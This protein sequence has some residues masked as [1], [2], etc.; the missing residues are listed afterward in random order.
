MSPS[1]SYER[2][3]NIGDELGYIDGFTHADLEPNKISLDVIID[4]SLMLPFD[5]GQFKLILVSS[6]FKKLL[7]ENIAYLFRE[8]RRILHDDGSIILHFDGTCK[9]GKISSDDFIY[10][11]HFSGLQTSQSISSYFSNLPGFNT[12]NQDH[13]YTFHKPLI[14][15]N[16]DPLVSILIPAFRPDF[17]KQ[18]LSS[19]L[20]QTYQNIEILIGDDSL[21][22]DIEAIVNSFDFKHVPVTYIKNPIRLKERE[23]MFQL[24]RLSKGD[25]IKFLNHDDI[26]Y[27][28]CIE[29]MAPILTNFSE[30][31]LVTSKRRIIDKNGAN[32]FEFNLPM[33]IETDVVFYGDKIVNLMSE[34]DNFVGEPTTAI[35]RKN[36]LR[37]IKPHFISLNNTPGVPGA[38]GDVIMWI[39]LLG[40]GS[41]A[42]LNSILSATRSHEGQSQLQPY[43]RDHVISGWDFIRSQLKKM[44]YINDNRIFYKIEVSNTQS[45][46]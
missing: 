15:L 41:C 23:N 18:S 27:P 19:A 1:I 43:F 29:T 3:L 28:T 46:E 20:S 32:L 31:K 16:K 40:Q 25:Y 21:G 38:P 12:I 17:F 5:N 4:P 13:V 34:F 35:F 10:F 11:A 26:L 44:G 9:T 7:S 45:H 24:F 37:H 22:D 33:K 42:F 8:L 6:I 2:K 14:S 30:I 39:N 36:D